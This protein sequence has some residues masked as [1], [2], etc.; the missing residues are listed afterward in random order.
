MM[1][2][3][4]MRPRAK[5]VI[6]WSFLGTL[7]SGLTFA[8]AGSATRFDSSGVMQSV[9]A[10]APRFDYDPVT[11]EALGLLLEGQRTNVFLG[12]DAPA[13]QS[14]AVTAQAYTLSFYGTGSIVRSGASSGTI[15]G[16]GAYPA[17]SSVTFTPSAGTLTLTVSGD[18][19]KCQLEAGAHASSYIPTVGSAVTRSADGLSTTNI[20]WF[21]AAQG[22]FDVE[23]VLQG[24]GDGG[25]NY[26][27]TFSDGTANNMIAMFFPPSTRNSTGIIVVAGTS[28]TSAG[29]AGAIGIG[30]L[31]KQALSYKNAANGSCFNGALDGAGTLGASGLPSGITSLALGNR[32]SGPYIPSLYL[33]RFRYW[34]HTLD[35]ATLQRITT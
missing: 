2:L 27:A 17:R 31:S 34:N 5:P 18:V 15:N 21:N 23:F 7:P 19:Q 11:H 20:P 4:I 25:N 29:S 30:S 3:I 12:S 24:V 26:S 6:D 32:V 9:A 10:N 1:P 13:T 22:A 35:N 28:K 33:R 8:R 14:I 16:V